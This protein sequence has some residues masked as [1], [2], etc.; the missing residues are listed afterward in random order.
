[1]NICIVYQ[2]D[3]PWDVR[4]EKFCVAFSENGNKVNLIAK[5]FKCLQSTEKINDNF[6]I[7]RLKCY[8]NKY[9]NLLLN[10]PAFFSATWIYKIYTI[11]KK[12]DSELII[13]RDLPLA[14]SAI[15]VGK[16][17]RIPVA[18]DMAENYPEM[19]RDTWKY[20]KIKKLDI[21]IRNPYLLKIIELISL[22]YLDGV[23]TVSN[24]SKNR[25]ISL[26]VDANKIFVVGNTPTI[27]KISINIPIYNEIRSLSNFNILYVGGL[28][29]SRGLDV[30]IKAIQEVSN[31]ISDC[32]LIIVGSGPAL[33]NLKMLSKN[34]H[35]DDKVF[36][37]GWKPHD[38]IN[39]IIKASDVGI[40]PHFVTNHTDTTLPNKIFD[41]MGLGKPIIVS[42]SKSLA[43]IVNEANCGFVFKDKDF[44]SLAKKI[45][46]LYNYKNRNTIGENGKNAVQIKYNWNVDAKNLLKSLPF[47]KLF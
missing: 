15:F 18:M 20:G 34:L 23:Y 30:A 31:E 40:V 33:E 25:L 8:N 3:Y 39:S 13:V 44:K 12:N 24:E 35:I 32:A 19:I 26:N 21:L 6:T 28:E 5:N 37:L 22:R 14:L 11:S 38:L 47:F 43:N 27:N 16:I 4:I 36:L 1:M 29:E 41:Y 2:D 10:F 9:I 45:L 7:N 17:L 42:N 46:F